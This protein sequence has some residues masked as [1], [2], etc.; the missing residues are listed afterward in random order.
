MQENLYQKS[1][2]DQVNGN[3]DKYNSGADKW[4]NLNS[5]ELDLYG[6]VRG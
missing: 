4:Q 5:V 1:K 2:A 6:K 3:N